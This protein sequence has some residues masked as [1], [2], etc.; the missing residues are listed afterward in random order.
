M[1]AF[2]IN[3][4]TVLLGAAVGLL[5]G[6]RLKDQYKNIVLSALGL[7]TIAIGVKMAIGTEN[8]LYVVGSLI[9]GG[10]L[11]QWLRIEERLESL[12]EYLKQNTGSQGGNF[13][14]GFVTASLLFCVGPMTVVGSFED[15][16]YGKGELIY[17]RSLMDCFAA[18]ALTAAFGIGVLFSAAVVFIY[19][20]TLTLLAKY[21]ESVLVPAA[22]N[23]MS[24]VGGVIVI[25][26]GINVLGLSRIRVGNLIPALPLALMAALFGR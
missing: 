19:Q 11:G 14:L 21:L 13:V 25:G 16:L 10:F 17:I 24:A 2:V 12:G 23:E 26:I 9:V 6:N 18:V 22:V 4:L 15:G 3:T 7:V 8:F 1:Y 20:G 5:A